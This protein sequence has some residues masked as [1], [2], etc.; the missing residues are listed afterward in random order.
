MRSAGMTCLSYL[1]FLTTFASTSDSQTDIGKEVQYVLWTW[2]VAS[3]DSAT[4]EERQ[5]LRELNAVLDGKRDVIFQQTSPGC[6][7]WVEVMNWKPNPGT[8]GYIVLIEGGGGWIR[9]TNPEQLRLA[10]RK[11]KEVVLKKQDGTYLPVGVFSSYPVV[12]SDK[13]K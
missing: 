11:L 4:K 7:L 9:A 10:T 1:L 6:C 13:S 12:S 8:D 5:L 2:P 3:A